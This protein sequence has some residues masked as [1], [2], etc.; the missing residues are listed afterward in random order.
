MHCRLRLG[1]ESKL[2][3]LSA[4]TTVHSIFNS[5]QKYVLKSISA[6]SEAQFYLPGGIYFIFAMCCPAGISAGRSEGLDFIE[7]LVSVQVMVPSG[8]HVQPPVAFSVPFQ[9]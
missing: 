9:K 1:I 4:C 2:S 5:V 6:T 3:L 8:A 7:G